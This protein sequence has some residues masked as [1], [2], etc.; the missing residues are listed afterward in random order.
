MVDGNK[1]AQLEAFF[2][3]DVLEQLRKNKK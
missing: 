3:K 2:K 1:I